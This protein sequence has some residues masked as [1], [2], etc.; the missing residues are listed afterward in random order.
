MYTS[1]R[2]FAPQSFNS[3]G[4]VVSLLAFA[5]LILWFSH[6][7]LHRHWTAVQFHYS[8]PGRITEHP[9]G[10]LA[11]YYR[12]VFEAELASQSTTLEQA[13]ER[14]IE[15]YKRPPPPGFD[16]WFALARRLGSP[17]ID[18]YDSIEQSLRH[19]RHAS[20]QELRTAL[21]SAVAGG[22]RG[23]SWST[24]DGVANLGAC[25]WIGKEVDKMLRYVQDPLPDIEALMNLLD[26][27]RVLYAPGI[28]SDDE[29]W[30]DGHG[31]QAWHDV[32]RTCSTE[33]N[34]TPSHQEADRIT[35]STT[36]PFLGDVEASKNLCRH[37]EYAH[38]HGFFQSPTSFLY[39]TSPVPMFSPARLSTFSDILY[40]PPF[41]FGTR[42]QGAYEESL[43]PDWASKRPE[44]FWAGSTTGSGPQDSSWQTSHR[45]RFVDRVNALSN[46]SFGTVFLTETSPGTWEPYTSQDL[47]TKLYNVHFTAIIQC[48]APAC[49]A[50]HS[51]F[52]PVN[53]TSPLASL[54]HKF[55]FDIDGNS[56]SGRF[57]TLL[58]SRSA[59]LKQTLFKEWHD[60]RLVPWVHYFPVSMDMGELPE[61]M[62]FLALTERGDAIARQVAEAGREW[63]R[64]AL[65]REDA[66]VYLF[67]LLLE[68]GRLM[69][70]GE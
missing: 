10:A 4:I 7:S 12:S 34:I 17:I 16:H 41:Y 65:R 37:P 54:A 46:H 25:D 44:V 40:P 26:E 69:E 14:Y 57:Y 38:Q 29:V 67:R 47:L 15:R 39:T 27:P 55:V 18:N 35:K 61:M 43:D 5:I 36:L 48:S 6:A 2:T 23:C 13:E 42:D 24:S 50:Q 59:V 30:H 70:G 62:R 68:L 19:L 9:I 51:H 11:T 20:A 33:N 66:A 53:R 60:D 28:Q 64:R 58:E 8:G 22:F 31:Q 49:T 32:T 21:R 56:F 1:M 3:K 52:H 45:Q 63:S